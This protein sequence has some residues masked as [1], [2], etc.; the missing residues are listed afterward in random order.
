MRPSNRSGFTIVELLIVIVVIGILAVITVVA[1]N[2]IQAR[3]QAANVQGALAQVNKKLAAYMV[4]YSTYPAD[5]TAFDALV[6]GT[7]TTYQYTAT[8]STYC[9]TAT[10]GTTSYKADSA[11]TQPLAGACAGHGN[12]GVAP[13]TNMATNPGFESNTTGVGASNSTAVRDGTWAAAG[14]WSLMVTPTNAASTDSYFQ[15]GGDLGAFRMGMQANKTY[16]ISAT[17][18][19]TAALTGTIGTSNGTRQITAWYTVSG[20]HT[21]TKS[22]MA[23]NSAG[24]TRLTVTFSV[25]AT[26]TAAWLRFYHG[27]QSGAGNVWFDN[28]MITEG[29]TQYNYADG[30]SAN[31]VWNPISSPNNTTSTGPPA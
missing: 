12:G 1:Y 26:A 14:S 31:W 11:A 2:G 13:I 29:S 3:A 5:Q 15:Y 25:P 20:V 6:P 21:V 17:I 30:S 19:L 4:D 16:T 28:I 27:G 10:N 23:P 24:D 7:S 8:S 9:V 18:H 22:N